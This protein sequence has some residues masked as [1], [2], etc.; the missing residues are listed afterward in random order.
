MKKIL[1][2]FG[3][4]FV[5]YISVFSLLATAVMAG[6]TG[7]NLGVK[8][9]GGVWAGSGTEAD[10]YEIAD[11]QDLRK[12]VECGG[13]D[14]SGNRLY[15]ELVNDIAINNTSDWVNND[16]YL[17]SRPYTAWLSGTGDGMYSPTSIPAFRGSLQGNG[18]TISGLFYTQGNGGTGVAALF[19]FATGGAVVSNLK[20]DK[21]YISSSS[22]Y[23]GAVFGRVVPGGSGDVT[24]SYVSA[25]NVYL[26]SWGGQAAGLIGDAYH[27]TTLRI[28]SCSMVANELS[29]LRKGAMLADAWNCTVVINNCWSS[30][31]PLASD[32]I[33][34][35]KVTN[36][37]SDVA[38][39]GTLAT[40]S[41]LTIVSNMKGATAETCPRLNS[42]RIW[43]F[44]AN[45]YPVLKNVLETLNGVVMDG[46]GTKE[47]PYIVTDADDLRDVVKSGGVKDGN[48][49]YFE[50]ANDIVVNDTSDWV[51][52]DGYLYSRPY[53]AWLSGT[54]DGVNSPTTLPAFQGE[55][56]GNGYTISGLFYTQGNGG[57]GVTALFP[58]ATGGAVVSNLKLDKIYFSSSS[59]YI[60]AV[61]GRVVPGNDGDVVVSHVA[62]TNA[63]LKSWGGQA[64]GL[65]AVAHHGMGNALKISGC[66]MVANEFAGISKGAM[67]GDAWECRVTI[68]NCWSSGVSLGSSNAHVSDWTFIKCYSDVD[69]PAPL[70]EGSFIGIV[71]SMKG[72]TAETCPKLNA[73]EIWEFV[74]GDYP[75]HRAVPEVVTDIDLLGTGTK[76]DPFKVSDSEDLRK[77]VKSGGADLY[78]N[79][80]YFEL[81]NDIIINS[82]WSDDDLYWAP[83]E[84]WE[85]DLCNGD[86]TP[87]TLPAFRGSL[88]GN[89]YTIKG[90]HY[91]SR[92]G[93]PKT[94]AL[95]PFATGGAEVSNLKLD[96]VYISTMGYA[97][98]AVFGRVVPGSTEDVVVSYV[99]VNNARLK[100]WSGGMVAGL[101]GDAFH[102]GKLRIEGCSMVA[103]PDDVSAI[104]KSAMLADGWNC[105]VT[106]SNSWSSG[107]RLDSSSQ[108]VKHWTYSRCYSDV[109]VEG[110]VAE[111][112]FIGVVDN[113]KGATAETCPKLN[114]SI[115]WEFVDNDYPRH[116]NVLET[117]N[118]AEGAVWS[119]LCAY[120]YE[121]YTAE[122]SYPAE[123]TPADPTDPTSR[124]EDING[125]LFYGDGSEEYPYH[126]ATGEQLYKLVSQNANNKG[127]GV[128]YELVADIILNDV[129]KENWA[130]QEDIN[131]WYTSS[132]WAGFAGH[133]NGNG[134]IVVGM[135]YNITAH[136]VTMGLF[137]T[138]SEGA[139]V[140]NVGIVN[141]NMNDKSYTKGNTQ[142]AGAITG[143]IYD[144]MH[145][146]VDNAAENPPLEEVLADGHRPPTIRKCFGDS[147]TLIR[148]R[149]AGGIVAG[150]PSPFIIEDSYF[151]GTVRGERTGGIAANC[152]ARN[153]VNAYRC[154]CVTTDTNKFAEGNWGG[155]GDKVGCYAFES[156]MTGGGVQYL[157]A[158][159]MRG[160][161]A[162]NNMPELFDGN[163]NWMIVE[164]GSPVL[165]VFGDR[166]VKFS[167]TKYRPTVVEFVTNVEDIKYEPIS[168][169]YG[170]PVT[171]P[172]PTRQGY[173]FGG[174]YYYK[175]LQ[176]KADF[177][178]LPMVG[179]TLYA[180][181]V[182]NAVTQD[183]ENY[184]DTEYDRNPDGDYE[185]FRPGSA[186]YTA[187]NV[188]GGSK[189]LHRI[190]LSENEEDILLNYEETLKKGT[191]YEVT[192]WA[193][194][195]TPGASITTSLVR[196]TWP[197]IDIANE[198]ITGVEEMAK[199]EG[200]TP[201]EWK[202][203]TYRF[204][205]DTEWVSLRTSGNASF[206]FDE[207]ELIPVGTGEYTEFTNLS[208]PGENAL[209]PATA[210]NTVALVAL[211]SAFAAAAV[212]M[213][214]SKN[215][216]TEVIDD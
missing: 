40:G 47:S 144:Y 213:L 150:A 78:G 169:S 58:F 68:N 152:W 8:A 23:V 75:K 27:N 9:V 35:W 62:V 193:T 12:V 161:L 134:H 74:A 19:P 22:Q 202:Q 66:S 121:P 106:I 188:Y 37:Y 204:T 163:D 30:G 71:P 59:P 63:Y 18:Y 5:T 112:S 43:Q 174:W 141:A 139:V 6:F 14:G 132:L 60:G 178:T 105:S 7:V 25:T 100:T 198:P 64:V 167:D 96:N 88:Q 154:Y 17:Y 207:F 107:T 175:E 85:A 90:L 42:K 173:D 117:I 28:E 73:R 94:S 101:I 76:D 157:Y 195:D 38:N 214:F 87:A 183:F 124:V 184:P 103:K 128:H 52:D 118:G 180:K 181:W 140:E 2:K 13:V 29:A 142:Y 93:L 208:K 131:Q 50:L 194:T 92:D 51:N 49:L 122:Y 45:D 44:V 36:S 10:P 179:V 129:T 95:F 110:E 102:N 120:E 216:L 84:L 72:A 205:A 91:A 162:K 138:L 57:T 15:F 159:L 177:K 77:V 176:C 4:K 155:D 32:K 165:K 31:A 191:I 56:Q 158:G 70:A 108:N 186:G 16:S 136:D 54:G 125:K 143:Y 41:D 160:D 197:D 185:I 114:T 200:I 69:N 182:K 26:K 46:A 203:Y 192:F 82:R 196:N 99:S 135:A 3:K 81:T 166:A 20:L 153:A 189:S 97:A 137:P 171:L 11:A 65:V 113:M 55:L 145:H 212:V 111:S 168:G 172:T 209:S 119:G 33:G 80:L 116:R 147:D 109:A 53:T 127:E 83:Y 104:S 215:H 148:A 170:D 201:G 48:K 164:G 190:G 133:F 24:V 149:F 61:F 211:L 1:I 34:G 39:S 115:I 98:G 206:Y 123:Y 89:G 156:S 187:G 151:L 67:L 199:I 130:E 126:I 21:V 146:T 79:K 210:D 86:G